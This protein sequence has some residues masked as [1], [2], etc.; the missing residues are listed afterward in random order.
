MYSKSS[1]FIMTHKIN[2]KCAKSFFIYTKN[3]YVNSN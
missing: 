1:S 2:V 3:L